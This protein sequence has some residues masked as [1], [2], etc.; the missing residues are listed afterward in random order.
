DELEIGEA[1][2]DGARKGG[3]LTHDADDIERK[4]PSYTRI[5]VVGGILKHGDVRAIVEH[6]PVGALERR[7]LIVV[8]N[9]DLVSLHRAPV[10]RQVGR[11]DASAASVRAQANGASVPCVISDTVT[12][13][14]TDRRIPLA[15]SY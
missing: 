8:Q 4:E 7:G 14:P 2:D 11:T 5:R 1:L 12:V 13:R 10:Q 15:P 3:P 6:R 9:G